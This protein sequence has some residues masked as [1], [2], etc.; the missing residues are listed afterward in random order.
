MS[1]PSR[2][3]GLAAALLAA[4]VVSA[5]GQA[6]GPGLQHPVQRPAVLD[7]I[8]LLSSRIEA[9]QAQV[10]QQQAQIRLLESHMHRY[11]AYGLP[12]NYWMSIGQLR[13]AMEPHS[14]VD[15]NINWI[16][17]QVAERIP[18]MTTHTVGGTGSPVQP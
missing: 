2:A 17:I 12:V 3:V 1:K 6:P 13:A 5:S 4:L 14:N 11:S 9:L 15:I 8:A 10:T 18:T 7:P 16:P